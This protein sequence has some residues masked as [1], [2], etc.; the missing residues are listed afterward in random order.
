MRKGT[1]YTPEIIQKISETTKAAMTPEVC[2]KISK[3]AKLRMTPEFRQ[4][5]SKAT[6][7][8]MTLERRHQ[9]GEQTK[10]RMTPE[11]LQQMS[12]TATAAMTP[13]VRQ[14]ISKSVKAYAATIPLKLKQQ[15]NETRKIAMK[16]PEVVKRMSE[17]SKQ[18]WQNPEYRARVVTGIMKG[19]HAK[20]NYPEQ[21]LIHLFQEYNLPFRYVGG[22]EV[23]LGGKCP[24]FINSDGKKQLI[25]L[26]GTYFHDLLDAAR[27]TE[28]F[29]QYGFTTLII[30]EDELGNQPRLVKKIRKFTRHK[31]EVK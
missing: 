12:K 3:A 16:K 7:A 8:T 14:Q 4:K 1:H 18:R 22:G 2:A 11:V 6:S 21:G 23:I 20:P 17:L 10:A 31:Q 19:W 25:E 28:H 26:F 30:W 5:L 24:D 9:I 13:E 29:R 15:I 27:R